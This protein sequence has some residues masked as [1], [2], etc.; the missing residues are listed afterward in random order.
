M[1]ERIKAQEA[2][3]AA[4]EKIEN[5]VIAFST[6]ARNLNQWMESADET[7]GDPLNASSIED[8]ERFISEL[9]TFEQQHNEKASSYNE[10]VALAATMKENNVTDF[11][12]VTIE[13][14]T[15][16][17]QSIGHAAEKRNQSTQEEL[18][19]QKSNDLLRKEFADLAT[20]L[21]SWIESQRDALAASKGALEEQLAAVRTQVSKYESAGKSKVEQLE[22][23]N[24]KLES[25]AI[26]TNNY[27][28]LSYRT[29]VVQ[30]EQLKSAME[31]QEKLLTNEIVL[32]K[33]ADVSPEQLNEFK[34]VFQ[35][36][37]RDGN[38][39]L[40]RIELKAVMQTLGDEP[41]E[42]DMDQIFAKLDPEKTGGVT[43]ERFTSFMVEKTKDTV[44][45]D[46]ILESFK[47]LA[48]DK[49]FV[50][51]EDLRKVMSNERVAYLMEHMPAYEAVA[52]GKDYRKWVEQAFTR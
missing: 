40:S 14:I 27:T 12:G 5:M 13:D 8:A 38:G 49:E 41:T 28:N 1:G 3:L 10:L 29:V 18:Q 15:A 17:W 39:T 32:K 4:K 33:N 46:E 42:S 44:S 31:K 45:K 30:Y 16:K 52:G 36:F 37:D 6:K 2:E 26:N 48:N 43:F 50:T 25:A 22:K 47:S 35:H 21:V 11:S 7:L 19:R 9:K 24:Q 34:E 23:S 51:E 20:A